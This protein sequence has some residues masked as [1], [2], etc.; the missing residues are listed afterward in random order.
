MNP[1]LSIAQVLADLEAQ[2]AHHEE[3]ET[4][5]TGQEEFH[6]SQRELHA[7][8]LARVRERYEGFKAAAQAAGE[9]V[10]RGEASQA[11]QEEAER[12]STLSKLIV[13]L[14]GQKGEDEPFS[15][16]LLTQEINDRYAKQL[17]KP[18]R[19]R[20]VSVTLRRL[21]AGG[22]VRL[23][24]EGRAHHEATYTRGTG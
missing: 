6:R 5:H 15:P 18:A 23:V 10:R 8:K 12:P 24:E 9:E 22:R 3:Q 11:A 20:T 14:I 21:L 2:I 16:T 4:F 13:R 19:A 17:R 1:N 7:G